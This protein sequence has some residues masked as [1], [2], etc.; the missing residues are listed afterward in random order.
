MK[1][2]IKLKNLCKSELQGQ[3][4]EKIGKKMLLEA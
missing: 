3:L 2:N 4:N 1:E